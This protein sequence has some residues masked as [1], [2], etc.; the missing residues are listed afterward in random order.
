[1]GVVRFY[2]ANC[3]LFFHFGKEV[4][5]EIGNQV[6]RLSLLH[7]REA[8]T[9]FYLIS[10]FYMTMVLS[11]KYLGRRSISKF[12]INRI[13]RLWPAYLVVFLGTYFFLPRYWGN[14]S[15]FNPLSTLIFY[16]SNFTI[17]GS[18]LFW[19]FNFSPEGVISW[20]PVNVDSRFNGSDF[21]LIPP[22]TTVNIELFFY[23]F[24]PFF[25]R[26]F[27]KTMVLFLIS[28]FYCLL[29]RIFSLNPVTFAYGTFIGSLL[30]FC[31]GVFSYH[32]FVLKQMRGRVALLVTFAA[33]FALPLE[34]SAG[35]LILAVF[36]VPIIF[37]VSKFS[38]FDRFFGDLSYPIYILHWPIGMVLQYKLGYAGKELGLRTFV[39]TI[40]T[41]VLL[42]IVLEK[43]LQRLR[44]AIA[45]KTKTS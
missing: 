36:L 22:I 39:L 37:S 19:W 34:I 7:G 21:L 28:I 23:F 33:L 18:N 26:S 13:L 35:W 12:Y 3:V 14:I 15:E 42:Y 9:I 45:P 4:S 20:A 11:E 44:T 30:Y 24:A 6:V 31:L 41:A 1:M 25:V 16:V 2:L 27:K 32:L 29:V 43:P 5:F 17:V 40:L 38:K 8:V 10:G